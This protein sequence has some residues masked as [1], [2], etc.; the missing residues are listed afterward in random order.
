[1]VE[2][3]HQIGENIYEIIRIGSKPT[4][5]VLL[6][7][8]YVV[9]EADVFEIISTNN[10]LDCILLVG[11]CNSTT[12]AAKEKAKSENI[13]LFDFREFMGAINF[14]GEKFINYEPKRKDN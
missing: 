1:M 2:D 5:K 10:N 11:Y 6:V 7:D 8:I 3:F 13:G 4:I 9:S 12:V 14:T